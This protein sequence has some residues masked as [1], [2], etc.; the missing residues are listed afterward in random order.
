MID[1]VE[2]NNYPESAHY[3]E[4]MEYLN[5]DKSTAWHYDASNIIANIDEF[6]NDALF[7]G[8]IITFGDNN[9]ASVVNP[10][11][12]DEQYF[13]NPI[14]AFEYHNQYYLIMLPK[15]SAELNN[16]SIKVPSN[17][18]W[19]MM[20]G[21]Y[22]S[23]PPVSLRGSTV[24]STGTN[25]GYDLG[26]EIVDVESITKS[27][28]TKDDV[29]HAL[30]SATYQEPKSAESEFKPE[31]E[32][33]GEKQEI[34][35][36]T[37]QLGDNDAEEDVV[38]KA[39]YHYQNDAMGLIPIYEI[40][41]ELTRTETI[42]VNTEDDPIPEGVL[43]IIDKDGNVVDS[44]STTD[45]WHITWGLTEGEE[46]TI[47]QVSTPYPYRV[48]Q[49]D[50][51]EVLER[52]ITYVKVINDK[53]KDV[54]ISKTVSGSG[55]NT[56]DV[57]N[58]HVTITN[59]EHNVNH[60]VETPN[61]NLTLTTDNTGSGELDFTM[62]HNESVKIKG[63][64][65]DA[66]VTVTESANRYVASY[67]VDNGTRTINPTNNMDLTS[68]ITMGDNDISIAFENTL[69][70]ILPTGVY[71]TLMD[72]LPFIMLGLCL[73]GMAVIYRK[74]KTKKINLVK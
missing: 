47:H 46:Y 30:N 41:N 33:T 25:Y 24:P 13:N 57:S 45:E 3:D 35:W 65:K 63:V 70:M 16:V 31:F 68:T 58:Y 52:E 59:G 10:I 12:N 48:A 74:N 28:M 64:Y 32:L 61:G 14:L 60:V 11:N 8:S 67:Q 4:F 56:N 1:I 22:I 62:K 23:I 27:M 42:L 20:S 15:N 9:H 37:D 18:I 6:D 54:T 69:T 34:H 29:Q 21:R 19:L 44:W 7:E 53:V 49:D 39:F 72:I 40:A 73:A 51:F 38:Y 17:N 71:L 43:Q 50:T 66:V 5:K 2:C 36:M 26:N 55:A